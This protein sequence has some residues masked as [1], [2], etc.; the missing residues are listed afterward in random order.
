MAAILFAHTVSA[1]CPTTSEILTECLGLVEV[2]SIG[3]ATCLALRTRSVYAVPAHKFKL[4]GRM[5]A[6]FG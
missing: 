3:A 1:P 5:V 6:Y 4:M 2:A